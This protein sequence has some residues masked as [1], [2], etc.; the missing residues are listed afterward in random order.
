MTLH[1]VRKAATRGDLPCRRI[2]RRIRLRPAE[3]LAVGALPFTGEIHVA[4]PVGLFTSLRLD[5][6]LAFS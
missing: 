6:N 5:R 1:A 3:L 2:G 4:L